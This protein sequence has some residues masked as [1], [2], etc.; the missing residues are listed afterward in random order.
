M[1]QYFADNTQ[2]S[3]KAMFVVLFDVSEIH[4]LRLDLSCPTSIG[5]TS[6]GFKMART[7]IPKRPNRTLQNSKI[8]DLGFTN[9]D[10][11]RVNSL[12]HEKLNVPFI[13]PANIS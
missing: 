7:N 4:R 11:I 3:C 10:Q 2:H 12:I 5:L 13:T 6:I 1:V 9:R 8:V